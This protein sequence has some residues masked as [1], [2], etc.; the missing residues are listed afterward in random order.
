MKSSD[1]RALQRSHAIAQEIRAL[2]P[3]Y[4]VEVV[5]TRAEALSIMPTLRRYDV[6]LIADEPEVSLVAM[7]P[8]Q[9]V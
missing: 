7:P 6:V 2:H 1:E 5:R 8:K 3:E 4:H 9:A